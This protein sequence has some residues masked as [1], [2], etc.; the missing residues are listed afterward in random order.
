MLTRTRA[1]VLHTLKYG[2]A[3]MIVDLLTETNGRLSFMVHIPKTSKGKIKKQ[4]FQPLTI[5]E[6][7][8]D[9]RQK[10][11]LQRMRDVRVALPFSSIPFNPIKLSLAL[12]LSEFLSQVTRGEQQNIPLYQYIENS[13]GWLDACEENYANFHLV[14]MMRLVRF[15]GFWPNLDDFVEGCF[16]DLRN[17]SFVVEAPLHPDYLVPQEAERI[18]RLMRMSYE[19]MHLFR[20]SHHDRNRITDVALRYYRLHI[21]QM[22]ELKSLE[23]VRGL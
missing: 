16:F 2:D 13:I 9:Y 20:M 10:S 5:I 18:S 19:T 14:F 3:S 12:F 11:E 6:M 17:A 1:I 4:Y 15:L 7:E 21:P 22:P 23:V 8:F